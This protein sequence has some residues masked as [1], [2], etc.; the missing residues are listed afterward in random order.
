MQENKDWLILPDGTGIRPS[1]LHS[2]Y[3]TRVPFPAYQATIFADRLVVRFCDDSG[4]AGPNSIWID[5]LY[6]KDTEKV[7]VWWLS[8]GPVSQFDSRTW[9][10]VI[11]ARKAR[12]TKAAKAAPAKRGKPPKKSW[13]KGLW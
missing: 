2:F 5:S 3:Q 6:A 4:C 8:E 11:E 12:E 13:W 1:K 9:A 7:L 10:F